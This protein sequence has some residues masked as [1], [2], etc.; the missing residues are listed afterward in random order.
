M[1]TGASDPAAGY[2]Y[3]YDNLDRTTSIAAAISGLTPTVT[4][5]QQFDKNNNRTWLSATLG[6]TA[7][8]ATLFFYD[9]LNNMT[10]IFH[11]GQTGGNAVASKRVDFTYDNLE[12]LSTLVRS[13]TLSPGYPYVTGPPPFFV[14]G[15]MRVR[16]G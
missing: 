7:D 5:A 16:F 10:L 2:T 6:G 3:Q 11:G 1:L 15:V 14:P 8:F 9:T 13:P 4:L 12:R